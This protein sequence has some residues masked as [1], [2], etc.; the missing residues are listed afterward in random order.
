VIG[1]HD[2]RGVVVANSFRVRTAWLGCCARR[3]E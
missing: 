3:G 2:R 1:D